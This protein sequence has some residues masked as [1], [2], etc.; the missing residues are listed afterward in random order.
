[1]THFT[2]AQVPS[3]KIY[4]NW[5][6]NDPEW[7]A[8]TNHIMWCYNSLRD[9]E[10]VATGSTN[11][12]WEVSLICPFRDYTLIARE[13]DRLAPYFVN[14]T[15]AGNGD[16]NSYLSTTNSTGRCPSDFPRWTPAILH[17]NAF[18]RSD[19]STNSALTS[20]M[21]VT[22]RAF[23]A[24]VTAAI[25]LLKWTARRRSAYGQSDTEE[26][27]SW[28]KI[29]DVL[30]SYDTFTDDCLAL[31]SD[32]FDSF[33]SGA[34]HSSWRG[35]LEVEIYDET[36][37]YPQGHHLTAWSEYKY[38]ISID[39]IA[40]GEGFI[41][42]HSFDLDQEGNPYAFNPK[43]SVFIYRD[44][45]WSGYTPGPTVV[46]RKK[47]LFCEN[48]DTV[49]QGANLVTYANPI[50]EEALGLDPL[51]YSEIDNPSVYGSPFVPVK[52]HESIDYIL[53]VMKWTFAEFPQNKLP[54]AT[55]IETPDVGLDGIVEIMSTGG[56][57]GAETGTFIVNSADDSPIL[58]LPLSFDVAWGSKLSGKAYLSQGANNKLPYHFIPWIE[59]GSEWAMEMPVCKFPFMGL[60][61][62]HY[63]LNTCILEF[64]ILTNAQ[65]HIKQAVVL[66]PRGEVVVFDF[67]WNGTSF[68]ANGYPIGINRDREYVLYHD[69]HPNSDEDLKSGVLNL[70]FPTGVGHTFGEGHWTRFDLP[71]PINSVFNDEGMISHYFAQSGEWFDDEFC[72]Q[73]TLVTQELAVV[74]GCV[75]RTT[76]EW[77]KSLPTHVTY[78]SSTTGELCERVVIE[79]TDGRATRLDKIDSVAESQIVAGNSVL[80]G[81]GVKQVRTQTGD[82]KTGRTVSIKT[83]DSE[84]ATTPY[85][86]ETVTYDNH[87]RLSSGSRAAGGRSTSYTFTYKNESPAD[88]RYPETGLLV[89]NSVDTSTRVGSFGAVTESYNYTPQQGWPSL[90][91]CS[92]G[93]SET[94]ETEMGYYAASEIAQSIPL[95]CPKVPLRGIS[96]KYT[97]QKLNGNS[98]GKVFHSSTNSSS[99]NLNY[100]KMSEVCHKADSL[101]GDPVNHSFTNSFEAGQCFFAEPKAGGGYSFHYWDMIL[102]SYY[103]SPSSEWTISGYN[104]NVITNAITEMCFEISSESTYK[105]VT[106]NARGVPTHS[107]TMT[108]EGAT[109]EESVT[110]VDARGRP[111]YS[112][113]MDG[114]SVHYISY[115]V[116]GPRTIFNRDYSI[117]T[118]EYDP[119]GRV[120]KR[121]DGE[122]GITCEYEY[123]PNGSVIKQT[124][125]AGTLKAESVASYGLDGELLY[126]KDE[127]GHEITVTG[128]NNNGFLVSTRTE[129]GLAPVTETY[130]ADGVLK[131]VTGAGA[132]AR[133]NRERGVTNNKYWVKTVNP[134]NPNEWSTQWYNYNGMYAYTEQ[135]GGVTNAVA[136]DAKLRPKA[137][138]SADNVKSLAAYDAKYPGLLS[139]SGVSLSGSDQINLTSDPYC[140]S[141]AYAF[142]AQGLK[143]TQYSFPEDN[144]T[145]PFEEGYTQVSPDGRNGTFCIQGRT[146]SFSCDA[147]PSTGTYKKTINLPGGGIATSTYSKFLLC[148]ETLQEAGTLRKITKTYQYDKF[149]RME[150]CTT[151]ERGFKET[152][153]VTRDPVKGLVSNINS[154]SQG[155]ISIA[156]ENNLV[157][158]I[159]A[160]SGTTTFGWKGNG[161]IDN[162]RQDLGP[163]FSRA[164][165]AF[166][167]DKSLTRQ[168]EGLSSVLDFSYGND[169]GFEGKKRDNVPKISV[170]SRRADGRPKVTVLPDGITV[171]TEYDAAGRESGQTRT[172]PA[173][174][175]AT[176][177]FTHSWMRDGSLRRQGQVGGPYVSNSLT[178]A[179][180]RITSSTSSFGCGTAVATVQTSYDAMHG[181]P[182][183]ITAQFNGFT[184]MSLSA[185]AA[186]DTLGYLSALSGNG[187]T[188]VFSC[189]AGGM[190]TNTLVV[191]STNVQ[192]R[193]SVIWSAQAGKPA[194]V[195]YTLNGQFL[196]RWQYTFTNGLIASVSRSGGDSYRTAY[197]YDGAKQLMSATSTTTNG[198]ALPGLSFAYEYTL[199]GDT[200]KYGRAALQNTAVETSDDLQTTRIW[201]PYLHLLGRVAASNA[202]VTSFTS[203][204]TNRFPATVTAGLYYATPVL[205]TLPQT[206]PTSGVA[207]VIA[208][209]PSGTSD[210]ARVAF[211]LPASYEMPV[212]NGRG[213]I[214]SDSRR[215]YTWDAAERLISISNT[216]VSNAVKLAFQYYPDGR[217]AQ[218]T[219]SCFT[220]NAWVVIRSLHY[221]WQGWKL[222]GE[223]ERNGAGAI[224]AVR[225]FVWGPDIGGQQSASL[226]SGAEGVGGLLLIREWKPVRGMKQYLPLSDGLGNICGLIDAT[227]GSL[228]A[229]FDYDPY[230]GPIIERGIATDACPFRN[231]TRYYDSESWLYYYGYRYYDPSTTKWIS[232]DPLEEAGGWNLTCFC[233]NDPI[234]RFDPLGLAVLYAFDGTC[235][236]PNPFNLDGTPN[237]KT[238]VR[239]LFELY[240]GRNSY[241]AYG[242]GSGYNAD[243]KLME[244]GVTHEAMTGDSMEERA[245]WMMKNLIS[246]LKAE[247]PDK[248]VDVMGFSRGAATATYFLNLIQQRID[249][250]DELFKGIKIRFVA[251]FDQVPSKLGAMRTVNSAGVNLLLSTAS[252]GLLGYNPYNRITEQSGDTKFTLPSGMN[253]VNIPLHIVSLD[254]RRREFAVT[255]LKGAWQIGFRGVHSNVGGG[256]GN[257]F[258]AYITRRFVYERAKKAGLMFAEK[259]WAAS[260]QHWASLYYCC[261]KNRTCAPLDMLPTDNSALKWDDNEARKLPKGLLLHPSVDWFRSPAKNSVRG[262]RYF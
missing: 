252:L 42:D 170:T 235:N 101:R 74:T 56:L 119:F 1:M 161:S 240:R 103:K 184:N 195:D 157:K 234:N 178:R 254:D 262:Y 115:C 172:D 79:Y 125:T 186:H 143:T 93:G 187:F 188:N 209:L 23:I 47:V 121:I 229:E 109:L 248:V 102:P 87:Q 75:Y 243:G 105:D 43:A 2:I 97:E 5:P 30:L 71:T 111:E 45:Y 52:Y 6:S 49:S 35:I 215:Q 95:N 169:G 228:A 202:T 222:A 216:G 86:T 107:R 147:A 26:V 162:V 160:P 128:Q 104:P 58:Y 260:D 259:E 206:I 55:P 90:I 181:A 164:E 132:S 34:E 165:D 192:L 238:N 148:E 25:N 60:T 63:N 110:Y 37:R 245:E 118:I 196:R 36:W 154:S 191:V 38:G 134:D 136:Y 83:F 130:W 214:L 126:S 189:A 237:Y 88:Q 257:D 171:T 32:F 180:G 12:G 230:G 64:N 53:C 39:P 129:T 100:T 72:W 14:Y 17:S 13:I 44:I 76:V 198:V 92:I 16:F 144:S 173:N 57:P 255:D 82:R 54:A 99:G 200:F 73:S 211:S 48:Y 98:Y 182:S 207:T 220:N 89:R 250:G 120:K 217:R 233:S 80:Y 249:S 112:Y 114:T 145:T 141:N 22:N 261:A 96:L 201:Q 3:P 68:S 177:A 27:I 226:D 155:S 203:Y 151:D 242:I 29:A 77:E 106:V 194:R 15:L 50:A 167:R 78:H 183:L 146:G 139:V 123:D 168:N 117:T 19:W 127:A 246:E 84:G 61:T 223:C 133:F 225:H 116:H 122:T 4:E 20:W 33:I 156:H 193:R 212:Y 8:L 18:G 190:I 219:V 213:M 51:S 41:N 239:L 247:N 227:D 70:L 59:R 197:V 94:K 231:R 153:K 179:S 176:V 221:A 62:F 174:P 210:T 124:R 67:P 21:A 159:T 258:F 241:Y 31:R 66:R 204:K 40:D 251:L 224:T 85:L 69:R 232:K 46:G 175:S 108:K 166:G 253:F 7:N 131:S 208:T 205:D 142:T 185:T 244:S 152:V 140:V 150:T 28:S 236:H 65:T 81:T 138:V 9:R 24:E 11:L 10:C 256:E 149:N 135:P 137:D 218:K 158:Q 199:A 163:T 91:S 113:F